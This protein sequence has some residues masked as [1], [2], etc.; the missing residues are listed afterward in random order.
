VS[1]DR[2]RREM[3]RSARQAFR[4]A[5]EDRNL[6]RREIDTGGAYSLIW[7]YKRGSLNVRFAP[8]ATELLRR[9]E[10]S[11]SAIS[12]H[13]SDHRHLN[14]RRV[15]LQINDQADR[16]RHLRIGTPPFATNKVHP[17]YEHVA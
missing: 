12:G 10:M 9:R 16:G 1:A 14:F 5:P 13:S 2:S 8:K 3:R 4:R 17:E 15:R 6:R 7:F 11:R